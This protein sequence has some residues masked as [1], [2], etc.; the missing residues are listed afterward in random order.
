MATR[1]S[2][3]VMLEMRAAK[4]AKDNPTKS[5]D[6]H[7]DTIKRVFEM[8]QEYIPCTFCSTITKT[9]VHVNYDGGIAIFT[10]YVCPRCKNE[11][12]EK[13]LHESPNQSTG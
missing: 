6:L 3:D 8:Q 5:K 10:K 13:D 12:M 7:P 1:S 2:Y 11:F 9:D 4:E